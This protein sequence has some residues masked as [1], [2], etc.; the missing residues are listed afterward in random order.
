MITFILDYWRE[1][2][3]AALLGVT[4]YLGYHLHTIEDKAAE[5]ASLKVQLADAQKAPAAIMT[6]TQDFN[7]DVKNVKKTDCL[8]QPVPSNIV[9]LL[10]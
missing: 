7:K 4:F 9:N 3:I 1:F 10:H 2:A 8:N 6:F 5:N